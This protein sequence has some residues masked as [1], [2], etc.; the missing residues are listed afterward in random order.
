MK[1]SV[2]IPCYN[3]KDTINWAKGG[4][5]KGTS[6]KRIAFLRKLV[7]EGPGPLELSDISRDNRTSTAGNGYYI[8]YFGKEM[9]EYWLFNLPVKNSKYD[10]L[11]QGTRFK[12]EIID[13]WEMT[14]QPCPLTFET[15]AVNDYRL[16]DK[17]LKKVRLPLKPYM[18][19]RL[20]EIH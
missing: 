16:F 2:I 11:K 1:I 19:L 10:K 17:D 14:I 7:E 8:I 3:E 12:V 6:W 9:P 15:G 5:Y 18:A 4:I 20:T 13:T